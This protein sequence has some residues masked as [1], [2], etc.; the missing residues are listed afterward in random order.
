[1]LRDS[2]CCAFVKGC[3][4]WSCSGKAS[5]VLRR[6]LGAG[7]RTWCSGVRVCPSPVTPHAGAAG[8]APAR[9]RTA[10]QAQQGDVSCSQLRYSR[11]ACCE[12]KGCASSGTRATGL[13]VSAVSLWSH[14]PQLPKAGIFTCAT[15]IYFKGSSHFKSVMSIRALKRCFEKLLSVGINY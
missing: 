5:L 6:W 3:R 1:M 13:S 15:Q 12:T 2:L 10:E 11:A 14:T 9:E 4:H 7:S 8:D